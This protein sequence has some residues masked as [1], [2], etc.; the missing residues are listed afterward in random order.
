LKTQK[1]GYELSLSGTPVKS[2]GGFI[3]NI[4]A[5]WSTYKEVFKELPPGQT[6]YNTFF[7]VGD[8][9]DKYYGSAFVRTPDGQIINGSN[10]EPLV[11]PVPQ[12]LGHLD[13]DW[14]W[15]IYNN[16]RYKNLS[17]G[18]Q[19]DGSVGG[20]TRDYVFNKTM[21]GGANALTA[22]GAL[23]A[24]RYKD[25]QN[26]PA[27]NV[28][29]NPNYTGSYIGQGVQISN[30]VAPNFDSG[31]GAVLNY[32]QLQYSPNNTP[33]FVQEYVSEY[34]N[35]AEA[36]LMSKTYAKL[37][38]VTLSYDL[39]SKWLQN[40]FISKASVTVYGRNLLYFYK[41]PKFKDVD[42]DQYA[43]TR[44]SLTG[45]QSPSVRSYGLNLKVSF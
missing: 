40:T 39:P 11:N 17:L 32:S 13:P 1:T 7:H 37:R 25:W 33:A 23:G 30:G 41:D 9:V 5:N 45:L 15:S 3:W 2:S 16:V 35:V 27:N 14:T 21:R 38:E 29:P 28:T 42:L 18:F 26:F 31:T 4:T 22:E 43:N 12:Y 34:Y 44:T 6:V 10:G 36:Y 20:V 24:A 8:R 19:F